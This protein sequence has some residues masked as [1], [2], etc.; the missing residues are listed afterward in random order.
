MQQPPPLLIGRKGDYVNYPLQPFLQLLKKGVSGKRERGLLLR[1]ARVPEG[2]DPLLVDV[3]SV[4]LPPVVRHQSLM[5]RA[6]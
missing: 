3:A 4:V 2:P 1:A 5:R 6:L